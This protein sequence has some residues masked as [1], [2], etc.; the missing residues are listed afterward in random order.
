MKRASLSPRAFRAAR[1]VESLA[2]RLAAYSAVAVAG[3]SVA[4]AQGQSSIGNIT[5]VNGGVSL[6]MS[7]VIG[8]EFVTFTLGAN[9]VNFH[10]GF[11]A[12]SINNIPKFQIINRGVAG[13]RDWI[14]V[15]GASWRAARLAKSTPI[16]NF[17]GYNYLYATVV[18]AFNGL[19]GNFVG[20][21]NGNK[22][23]YVGIRHSH[24]GH[25]YYGWLQINVTFD[26]ND[27]PLT[28]ALNPVNGIYGAINAS[29][30]SA[31][32]AGQVAAIPEAA[33]V[34]TGLAL[35]ALGAAGVREFRRR[36]QLAA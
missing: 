30:D 5:A 20:P 8:G 11:N 34:A 22:T 12:Y 9:G 28:I 33:S 13:S 32:L 19:H 25:N 27:R 24:N 35:F 23:G 3:L 29:P 21:A 36:R 31:I 7:N 16:I 26:A 18:S 15:S 17:G 2:P 14:R 10:L 6:H 1:S 4:P